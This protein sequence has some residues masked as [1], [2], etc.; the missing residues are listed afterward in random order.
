L[1]EIKMAKIKFSRREFE[2]HIK[3][4]KEVEDR[5]SMMGTHLES[6]NDEEIELEI[7]PNR[8][9]LFSMQ[10]FI[11]AFLAFLGKETGLKN[12]KVH[13]A[14]NSFKVKIDQSVKSVRPYTACAIVKG[15]K[16]DDAKIKEIID[17]QEKLHAT[18][19]R[20][21]EKMA[22]GVYPLEKI[23]LPIKYEAR[24]PTEIK[25]IPLE[26][27]EEMNALQ[28]LQR[29]PTGREYAYL[30]DG[31]DK[32]PVFVDAKNKIL[33]MPPIINSNETGKIANETKDIFIE[34]SGFDF[35]SQ[36]KA[37]NILVTSLADM[38][39]KIYAMELDYGKKEITPDL[40]PEKIK[41]SLDSVN[42][43]LGLDLKE[44][45]LEKLLLRMG[46]DYKK[47][48][49]FVPAW[50][51]DVLHEVD[52]IE[53]IAIAY[54]YENLIPEIPEV[55]TIGQISNESKVNGKI[56]EIIAGL[57]FLETSSLHLVKK[58]EYKEDDR[59]EV[60]DSKTDYK[61]LRPSLLIP[62]LR[63]FAENKDNEY[64]Q[65][66]FEMGKVFSHDKN[67]ETGVREDYHLLIA[68]SPG[69]FTELKQAFDY[70]IRMLRLDYKLKESTHK[71]MIE[72]RTGDITLEGKSIGYIGE[73][74][75]ETLREWNIKM[76]LSVIEIRLNE[77]YELF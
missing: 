13:L 14:E 6:I 60:L 24:K 54:G 63:I 62:A 28:I 35:E 48:F 42:K 75:P 12:Y 46:Y 22:I 49:A 58:E 72:G 2:K 16:F 43:L 8:P 69:S 56:A 27:N 20:N 66:I 37:L 32:Y 4:T 30:L 51:T 74:H 53:D 7:L 67:S 31:L 73:V 1:Q 23:A 15:L 39:G 34:V 45:D 65:K 25:F 10:G 68:S 33:S 61:I 29:H 70:L 50:R 76:P 9:D 17:I 41:V 52:I 38:G 36:K 77:I 11:R 3:I 47:G 18:F 21:R 44:K 55:A 5:I 40:S 26:M 71:G 64:P 19:G 59:I 57:G